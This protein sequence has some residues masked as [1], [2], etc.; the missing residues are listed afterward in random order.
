MYIINK[1]C[2]SV[3][4]YIT[5]SQLQHIYICPQTYGRELNFMS[6]EPDMD[7][8]KEEV[9]VFLNPIREAVS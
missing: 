9:E 3:F 1:S 6:E 2:M 4:I 7:G 5:F 8:M